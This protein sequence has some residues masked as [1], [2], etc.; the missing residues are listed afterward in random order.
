MRG[1]GSARA[2]P[3][4]ALLLAV[5]L[6][7][8][9]AAAA[10]A[11]RLAL[12]PF[13]LI[14]SSLQPGERQGRD[15]A[16]RARLAMIQDEL[17]AALRNSGRYE[18]VDT[19][20]AAAAIEA[21]GYLWSCNG[22]ELGI[23]RKLDADL[24]LVGWVQKVSNLILNLNVV[25]REHGHPQAG[26]RGQRRHPGRHRRELAPWHALSDPPSPAAG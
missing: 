15:P 8:G 1:S 17:R 22:C 13:E 9:P 6:A 24:A 2:L 4:A 10:E 11:P 19:T 25:V 20:P 21:A 5:T 12:F 16:D 23:A 26:A 3:L 14:D 7:A 18:L